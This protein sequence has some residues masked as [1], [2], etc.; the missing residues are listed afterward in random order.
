MSLMGESLAWVQEWG[1]VGTKEM[2]CLLRQ[3]GHDLWPR[4]EDEGLDIGS[5][6]IRALLR[7][8]TIGEIYIYLGTEEEKNEKKEERRREERKEG[9]QSIVSIL[10]GIYIT[11]WM[12][13]HD[14]LLRSQTHLAKAHPLII[15]LNVNKGISLASSVNI[16]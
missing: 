10:W 1:R 7:R 11:Q 3:S 2:K 9:T 16:P 4:D 5:F 6:K 15:H 14:S 8:E 12:G 13:G